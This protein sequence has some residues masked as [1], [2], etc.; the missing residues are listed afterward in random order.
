M[1][2][3]LAFVLALIMVLSLSIRSAFAA[4]VDEQIAALQS[5]IETLK[6]EQQQ[7]ANDYHIK[8]IIGFVEYTSPYFIIE[9]K[10][11]DISMIFETNRY[12]WIEDPES[13]DNSVG[14]IYEGYH[15][16]MGEVTLD[17]GGYYITV[18]HMGP[19]PERYIELALA[20]QEKVNQLEQ[21]QADKGKQEITEGNKQ[22]G[23]DT[24][25]YDDGSYFTGQ[26][27]NGVPNGEGTIYNSDGVIQFEGHFVNGEKNGFGREYLYLQAY[28]NYH[29]EG[30]YVNGLKQGYFARYDTLSREKIKQPEYYNNDIVNLGKSVIYNVWMTDKDVYNKIFMQIGNPLFLSYGQWKYHEYQN[31]GAAPVATPEGRTLIP[32]RSFIEAVGGIVEWDGSTNQVTVILNPSNKVVFTVGNNVAIVNGVSQTMDVKAQVVNGKTMIPLRFA[33]ESVGITDLS[34]DAENQAITIKYPKEEALN[35]GLLNNPDAAG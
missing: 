11:P 6:A 7:I 2:R 1:K 35:N 25:F 13:G 21:L 4:T 31:I 28:G 14:Y 3:T 5:E 23:M 29:I 32:I 18:H 33:C 16:N 34:Y 10:S 24:V 17:M 8:H 26:T 30:N 12:Y 15:S 9:D 22:Q 19:V 27:L 20:I